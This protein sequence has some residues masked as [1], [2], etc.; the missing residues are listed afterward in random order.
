MQV[1]SAELDIA[2]ALQF[3]AYDDL[4]VGDPATAIENYPAAE[5]AFAALPPPL[6]NF[7]KV[8]RT[9]NEIKVRVADAQS[10]LGRLDEAE[11]LIRDALADREQ[12][13]KLT[14]RPAGTVAL[15]KTDVGQSRM[16][17]GDFL[18]MFRKDRAAA[19]AEYAVGLEL[20][21]A[22]LKEEPDS[23]DL[24]QRLAAAHYRLGMTAAGPDRAKEAYA[25]CLKVRE[26][27]ARIDP[28]DTQSGVELALALARAGKGPDAERMADALLKQAGKDRQVLF[29]VACT[30]SVM[31]GTA[32]DRETAE[33]RRDQAFQ[34]LR[35]LIK[36]GWKDR[37]GLETDPDF[38]AIRDDRRFKEL[39][40]S[41]PKPVPPP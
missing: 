38:D 4:R 18:L 7:M 40:D 29:Q 12:L 5:K 19:A 10:K 25:E 21:A 1:A 31:S 16:Y 15:L 11:K 32:A 37:A 30:Y 33:R 39:L 8:R 27:L 9:R 22:L 20:F 2:D 17:V 26:E 36:A 3:L 23:L 34:A 6:P 13:V 41:L 35:D 28:K 14:P 24:R